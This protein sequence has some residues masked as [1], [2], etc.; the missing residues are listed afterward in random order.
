VNT[1]KDDIGF[2]SLGETLIGTAKLPSDFLRYQNSFLCFLSLCS[3]VSSA[4]LINGF[5][6]FRRAFGPSLKKGNF[7]SDSVSLI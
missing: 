7:K 4:F 1:F 5:E 2:A 6:A 3:F